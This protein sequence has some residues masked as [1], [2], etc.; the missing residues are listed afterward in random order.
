MV[1]VTIIADN[2]VA[3]PFPPRLRGEWG[4]SAVVDDILFDT[5]H[6]GTAFY[7]ANLLGIPPDFACIVLSHTHMDH[8]SGLLHFLN[9]M[10]KPTIYLHPEVWEPRYAMPGDVPGNVPQDGIPIGIP[11]LRPTIEGMAIIHEH[12]KP[13]EVTDGVF[14]LGEIPRRH[15][16]T[17]VGKIEKNGELVEDDVIDDQAL[18]ITTDEGIALLLGCCHAGLRNSVEYAEEVCNGEVRYII[19]GTHLVAKDEQGVREIADWLDGKVDLF[20]GT[21]CTGFEAES[22]LKERLPDEFESVGVG[23]TIEIPG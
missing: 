19:G 2:T 14:A 11:F 5:G 22:V 23:S 18:A 17:T 6:S 15:D 7:N 13:I 3:E 12:R 8:T 10:D 16:D 9:I 4:F 1:E 20:A 21:H